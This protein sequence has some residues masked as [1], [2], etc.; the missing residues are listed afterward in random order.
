MEASSKLVHSRFKICFRVFIEIK[1]LVPPLLPSSPPPLLP[2]S[3][4]YPSC[5]R[6]DMITAVDGI[7]TVG[8]SLDE[9]RAAIFGPRGSKVTIR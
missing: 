8:M 9:L 3:L 1:S 7:S 5:S 6:G 2:S 4:L